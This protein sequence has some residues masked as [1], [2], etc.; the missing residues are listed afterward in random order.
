MALRD[1]DI[2]VDVEVDGGE[3][4]RVNQQA[5]DLIDTLEKLDK[6]YHIDID[7][8]AAPALAQLEELEQKLRAI[9][10]HINIDIDLDSLGATA[11]L[12][13]LQAQLAAL[14]HDSPDI[15]VHAQA[16]GAIVELERIQ[17]LV[18]HLDADD[19][20]LNVDIDNLSSDI[21]MLRAQIQAI[22]ASGIDVHMDT[23]GAHAQL[24]ALQAHLQ[25]LQM[26]AGATSA[27]SGI[28]GFLA[29]MNPMGVIVGGGMAVAAISALLVILPPLA[30]AANVAIGAVMALGVAL[31]TLGGAALALGSA[32]GVGAI[33]LV[34]FGA[35]AI[36]SITA[37]YEEGAKLTSQQRLLKAQTDKVADSWSGLKDAL[38]PTILSATTSG[39]KAINTLL[40]Q[41][42][43]IL[44]NTGT[45]VDGLMGS[46]NKSLKGNEMQDFF[47][48]LKRDVGPLTTNL[49][50]GLGNALKGVANTMTA[51]S[52]LTR[53]VGD[54][55]ESMMGS[56]SDWTAGLAGSEK[57]KSFMEYIKTNAPKLGSALGNATQGVT[58]LVAGFSGISADGFTWFQGKMEQFN[59]W[60]S[61]LGN[62]TGFQNFLNTIK[63]NAPAVGQ[64]L[65]ELGSSLSTFWSVM[66]APDSNGGS[67][68]QSFA[69]GL[70]SI[71]NVLKDQNLQSV[72]SGAFTFDISKIFSGLTGGAASGGFGGNLEGQIEQ[73]V[74]SSVGNGLNKGF[75][76]GISRFTP[77]GLVGNALSGIAKKIFNL[78]TGG[79][80]TATLIPKA[81]LNAMAQNTIRETESVLSGK[82][83]TFQNAAQKQLENM[84][85]GGNAGG[86]GFKIKVDADTTP[87][88]TAMK[89]MTAEEIQAKVDADTAAAQSK[90][91]ALDA[92]PIKIETDTSAIAANISNM[93]A[94]VQLN[95]DTSTITNSIQNMPSAKVKVSA[96]TASL[97][98]SIGQLPDAKISLK[99]D[100]IDITNNIKVVDVPV[101]P[102]LQQTSGLFGTTPTTVNV[103]PKFTESPTIDDVTVN[104]TFDY[105]QPSI[106][107]VSANLKFDYETP[108][109]ESVSAKLKFNY[110]KPKVDPI[111]VK[112]KLQVD[113]SG[114]GNLTSGMKVNFGP[115]PKFTWPAMPKFSWPPLPKF[116]WPPLPKWSWPP[117]PKFTW[118]AYPRFSW[119]PLPKFSWPPMPTVKVSV[120]GAANGSHANGMGRIPF[121]GYNSILH[122]DETVLQA[123]NADLLRDMGILKGEGEN[124]SLDMSAIANYQPAAASNNPKA[125]VSSVNKS[126]NDNSKKEY[127]ITVHVDGSKNP[128]ETAVSITDHLQNWLASIEDA[129]PQVYEY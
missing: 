47:A 113:K 74:S 70:T 65:K 84:M 90:L 9:D 95:A 93:V 129:N 58:K 49:G 122:K 69:D 115:M 87:A 57:M 112:A 35:V 83:T 109:I 22:E 110:E 28:S 18:D 20:F 67:R 30:V 54:G 73:E 127:N 86:K 45:A 63:D 116:S 13:A 62:N 94:T 108:E 38:Q 21:L 120:S 36:S 106:D 44:K 29:N 119:P 76:T 79:N 52:P 61:N 125:R 37:L 103:T 88:Q 34:G 128:E 71:S 50:N 99:A 31:G 53:W 64:I 7:L 3:L 123:H 117:M 118:P 6:T 25:A 43:P 16:A 104:V 23:A 121:D 33:G 98:N 66:T 102:I 124:P 32:I 2:D 51:L 80:T 14:D 85:G 60:A 48:M 97:K 5:N 96:D 59:S 17:N 46:L 27:M 72:I 11:Q 4:E 24:A 19:I 56:F 91:N 114:V 10:N 105:E 81:T 39:V 78:D 89:S 75:S 111:T 15:D 12:A 40:D 126:A 42:H 68:L 41:G 1:L 82:G 26:Q 92:T 8:D 107:D 77:T 100:K 55:F 101:N